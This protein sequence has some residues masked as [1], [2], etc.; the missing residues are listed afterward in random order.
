[1]GTR[2]YEVRGQLRLKFKELLAK[3]EQGMA[4]LIKWAES[5]GGKLG[6]AD[7]HGLCAVVIT[8]EGKAPKE[9]P[10]HWKNVRYRQDGVWVVRKEQWEPRLSTKPGKAIYNELKEL[11]KDVPTHSDF[12][13]LIKFNSFIEFPKW[14]SIGIISLR[15]GKVLVKVPS[16]K[17]SP[18]KAIAKDLKRISDIEYEKLTKVR[19]PA[20]RSKKKVA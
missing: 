1:M 19:K 18:P 14:L 5:K 16:A 3:R 12:Q 11:T 8:K 15:T 4:E 6:A 7:S 2:Y 17:Y 9:G 10:E 20:T 13:E